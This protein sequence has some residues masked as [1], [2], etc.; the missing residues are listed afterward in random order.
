MSAFHDDEYENGY[1]RGYELGYEDGYVAGKNS[2][3]I[4][5][6]YSI[7]ADEVYGGLSDPALFRVLNE[8]FH[9][10]LN[11]KIAFPH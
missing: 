10:T 7:V 4:E 11:K 6:L 1:D 2:D 8:L 9:K 5:S 3:L